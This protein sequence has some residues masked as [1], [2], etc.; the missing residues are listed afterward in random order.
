MKFKSEY[1][2]NAIKYSHEKEGLEGNIINRFHV[3]DE[4]TIYKEGVSASK[5]KITLITVKGIYL[6][7]GNKKDKYFRL[8]E[9]TEIY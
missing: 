8:D 2:V 9:I 1:C 4:V 7:V 5:G 3:G 6:D